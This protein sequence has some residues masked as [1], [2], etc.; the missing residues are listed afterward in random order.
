MRDALGAL[1]PVDGIKPELSNLTLSIT[2]LQKGDI[3]LVASDGLTDNFDPNVCKFTVNCDL[4]EPAKV[5]R[6]HPPNK[7]TQ[8]KPA[9]SHKVEDPVLR[10]DRN[11]PPVKPPRKA[12]TSD[13]ESRSSTERSIRSASIESAN[14]SVKSVT[15]ETGNVKFTVLC[16]G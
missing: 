2:T 14:L 1:G 11:K 6:V 7:G 3:I 5:K 10:E 16:I 12:K 4:P 13:A 8:S 9:V 15:A